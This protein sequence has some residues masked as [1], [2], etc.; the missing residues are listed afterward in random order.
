MLNQNTEDFRKVQGWVLYFFYAFCYNSWHTP[1]PNLS[2][3]SMKFR[4]TFNHDFVRL[5]ALFSICSNRA[6]TGSISPRSTFRTFFFLVSFPYIGALGWLL[7]FCI[8]DN[9][10]WKVNTSTLFLFE[11][12]SKRTSPSPSMSKVESCAW[13][14]MVGE[15]DTWS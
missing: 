14:L 12:N 8:H 1:E 11:Q 5:G 2:W 9:F 15:N 6:S 7:E 3:N 13:W 4:V 10:V